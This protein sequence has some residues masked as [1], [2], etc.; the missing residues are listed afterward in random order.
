MVEE[1]GWRQ[2][3]PRQLKRRT[4]GWVFSTIAAT[5]EAD[6]GPVSKVINCS[7]WEPTQRDIERWLWV[8]S[9]EGSGGSATL[10]YSRHPTFNTAL[11]RSGISYEWVGKQVNEETSSLQTLPA[12]INSWLEMYEEGGGNGRCQWWS[13]VKKHSLFGCCRSSTFNKHNHVATLS[14]NWLCGIRKPSRFLPTFVWTQWTREDTL[15]GKW[16][17]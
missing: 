11:R 16:F 5:I 7:R 10:P 14:L 6:A 9:F 4:W 17:V 12:V 15:K 3:H 2:P 8:S 1:R 13:N